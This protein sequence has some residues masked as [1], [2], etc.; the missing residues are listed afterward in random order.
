MD[1][2]RL[3]VFHPDSAAYAAIATRLRGATVV[4]DLAHANAVMLCG[5]GPSPEE[6]FRAGIPVLIVAVSSPSPLAMEVLATE[7]RRSDAPLAVVNPDRYLPSR[8]LI[9]KQLG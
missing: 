3:A 9:R 1:D 4:A 2:I 8:Q 7:S 6:L 5:A